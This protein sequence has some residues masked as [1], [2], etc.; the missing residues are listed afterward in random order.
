MFTQKNFVADFLREKPNFY[1]ENE[2]IAFGPLWGLGKTYAVHVRFIG[3]L[4]VDFL[5]V[6][7]EHFSLGVFVLSQFMRLIV[8]TFDG[9]TDGQT[10]GQT[11]AR[12]KTSP[13]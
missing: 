8:N 1:T 13:A 6:I 4:V 7:I 12:R 9:R 11:D 3:K 5:L 10:H 2:K